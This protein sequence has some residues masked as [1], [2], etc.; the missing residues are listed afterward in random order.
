MSKPKVRRLV[1]QRFFRLLNSIVTPAVRD[2]FGSP[3]WLPVGLI[4]LE[5]RGFKSGMPRRT[6]LLAVRVEGHLIVSTG[7][8]DRSFWV[9]NLRK[10]PRARYWLAGQ[11][12]QARASV[13]VGA[14]T[15]RVPASLP[16]SLRRV[17][18]FLHAYTGKGWA[19]AILAPAQ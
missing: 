15:L 18:E 9:N 11:S 13:I 5:S 14:K 12:H 4:L 16:P 17:A 10:T 19:F 3:R 7:R 8:G 6:P 2:G 1:E